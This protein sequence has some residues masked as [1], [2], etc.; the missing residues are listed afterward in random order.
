MDEMQ[1]Y[2]SIDSSYEDFSEAL[3]SDRCFEE[4]KSLH[5]AATTLGLTVYFATG[6]HL[7]SNMCRGIVEHGS[8]F[9]LACHQLS[10]SSML[11]TIKQRVHR[12]LK[13]HH[14]IQDKGPVPALDSVNKKNMRCGDERLL[15]VANRNVKKKLSS[16]LHNAQRLIQRLGHHVAYLL[17][18]VEGA[19]RRQEYPQFLKNFIKAHDE[20]MLSVHKRPV[21]QRTDSTGLLSQALT[22]ILTGISTSLV[23]GTTEGRKLT[24]NERLFYAAIYNVKG[25]W[26]HTLVQGV[27]LGP[28]LDTTRKFRALLSKSFDPIWKHE[29]VPNVAG[30]RDVMLAM[31]E[32]YPGL[33]KAP[34]IIAEDATSL[35]RKLEIERMD[36]RRQDNRKDIH[37]DKLTVRVW[38]LNG[39]CTTEFM[40]HS[41]KDLQELMA[42]CTAD[43]VGCH[44]YAWV[45]VPQVRHAPWF[46]MR[47][48]VTNNKF[49]KDQVF[50]WWRELDSAC[51]KVGLHSIGHVGDGDARMRAA[52]FYLMRELPNGTADFK[53]WMTGRVGVDHRLM[54]FLKVI[55]PPTITAPLLP[56]S[57]SPL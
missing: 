11:K 57:V 1:A 55:P 2:I 45:W 22:D 53:N 29:G 9:C 5:T 42:N 30:V 49:T 35:W 40:I 32:R 21:D 48:D 8:L 13:L 7:R 27:M 23:A 12:Q 3:G 56:H 28:H 36:N 38:G 44:L 51:S 15:G 47:I 41:V 20:G 19:W 37:V 43:D 33:E 6:S 16:R 24:K 50:A 4:Q 26:A 39:C 46:P 54:R 17:D 52:S 14:S 34:G 31:E 25:P 10:S 18:E